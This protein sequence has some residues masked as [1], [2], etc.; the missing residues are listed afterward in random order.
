MKYTI[1]QIADIEETRYSF[2]GFDYAKKYNFAF[3]DYEKVYE[4][5]TDDLPCKSG[6]ADNEL[7][8][9]FFTFN[10]MHPEDF[11]SR[12]L[13]V[14]DIVVL[15]D[16]ETGVCTFHYCNSFGWRDITKEV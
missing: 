15:E 6:F 5:E 10:E 7:E 11:E 4:G 1:Y 2:M 16:P 3:S 13:S 12:S 8:D 9:I 14:S